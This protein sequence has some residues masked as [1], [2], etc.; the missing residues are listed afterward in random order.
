MVYAAPRGCHPRCRDGSACD[1]RMPGD[2]GACRGAREQRRREAEGQ[3]QMTG[4]DHERANHPG[5]APPFR[6]R[7]GRRHGTHRS[8]WYSLL[9]PQLR[10]Q[11]PGPIDHPELPA[12]AIMARLRA[13]Q[14][15]RL[16]DPDFRGQN[17]LW[18]VP[19]RPGVSHSQDLDRVNAR[20][21]HRRRHRVTGAM[22]RIT[23]YRNKSHCK[24]NSEVRSQNSEC[25]L[26]WRRLEA[27]PGAQDFGR[28]RRRF[29]L[30]SYSRLLNSEF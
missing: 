4:A 8:A 6:L 3:R 27:A 2:E 21:H 15:A 18:R 25:F 1:V 19:A 28:V 9:Q 24:Q 12:A 29:V 30:N 16:Q 7:R 26:F 5:E 23:I 14:R 22:L 17:A 10:F 13:P 11:N 20:T